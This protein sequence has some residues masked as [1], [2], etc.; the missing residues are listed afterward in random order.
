MR[1]SEVGN[2]SESYV[3]LLRGVREPSTLEELKES[4]SLCG[5]NHVRRVYSFA[6]A[7]NAALRQIICFIPRAQA[8]D[9]KVVALGCCYSC[10]SNIM[11]NLVSRVTM[12][13]V[14]TR[15]ELL[16]L[17]SLNRNT[18]LEE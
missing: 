14:I 10:S 5:I 1:M 16:M 15:E 17:Q 11:K 8:I 9:K 13:P 18:L 12:S 2:E 4:C 3:F 7:S 6:T